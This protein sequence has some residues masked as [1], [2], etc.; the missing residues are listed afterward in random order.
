M[1]VHPVLVCPMSIGVILTLVF[2]VDNNNTVNTFL[3]VA[4][5]A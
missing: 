1:L 2:V 5:P 3:C 4:C